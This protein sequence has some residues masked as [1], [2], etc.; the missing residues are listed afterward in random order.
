M[1]SS[2][3]SFSKQVLNHRTQIQQQTKTQLRNQH[4][5]PRA[6][7]QQGGRYEEEPQQQLVSDRMRQENRE[8]KKRWRE[9]NEERNKDNDLRCR[10]NKRANQLYG[11]TSS[12]AKEKWIGEEFE[13][14]QHRRK[15][16]ELRKRQFIADTEEKLVTEPSVVLSSKN[17]RASKMQRTET[18]SVLSQLMLP[19]G[20]GT[21]A[22]LPSHQVRAAY[23][24]WK[25]VAD[26]QALETA[27]PAEHSYGYQQSLVYEPS[28]PGVNTSATVSSP[29]VSLPPLSSVVP[30]EL[31]HSPGTLYEPSSQPQDESRR[32]PPL[33]DSQGDS[34][35]AASI[36]SF[37]GH[38]VE[39]L[40]SNANDPSYSYSSTPAQHAAFNVT[41]TNARHAHMTHSSASGLSADAYSSPVHTKHVRPW[42]DTEEYRLPP[43]APMGD[44]F[45]AADVDCHTK[46]HTV[47]DMGGLSEAAFSLMSLSSSSSSAM[48]TGPSVVT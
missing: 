47:A 19:G 12:A 42:E 6:K 44:S 13:R 27:D 11:A 30:E 39:P 3:R 22:G 28:S 45:A 46:T 20:F 34:P 8:R 5:G 36:S 32:L 4:T 17:E 23:G 40:C 25:C 10:V 1:L 16:K 21:Y 15:E 48:D 33:L 14:R 31:L 24:F 7:D 35:V 38:H 2:A 41:A 18:N 29:T 37:E 9:L 26:G 43:S